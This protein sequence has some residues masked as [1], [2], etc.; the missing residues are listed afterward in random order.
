MTFIRYKKFGNRVYAYEVTAYYDKEQ[1]RPRQKVKYLGKLT[2]EGIK[3]VRSS[4]LPRIS[5]N[6]GDVACL[7][8]IA[9]DIG[10]E[11]TLK[12]CYGDDVANAILALA[13]NR[14]VRGTSLRNFKVWYE[15]TYL[16]KLTPLQNPSSQNLSRIL[17]S[18]GLDERSM[19]RFFKAWHERNGVQSTITY[20]ITSLSSSSS[21]IDILEYGYNRDND[22]LPQLNLGLVAAMETEI[23]L[24]FKVFPGS[25]NDVVTLRNLLLE[26]QSIGMHGTIFILDR[27]FYSRTNIGELSREGMWFVIPMPFHVKEAQQIISRTRVDSPGNAV[28]FKGRRIYMSNGRIEI[29]GEEIGYFLYFDEMRRS[30]ETNTFYSRLIEVETKLNGRKI[31]SW[32][33]AD[34]VVEDVAGKLAPYFSWKVVDGTLRLTRRFRTISRA[35][36]MMGKTILLYN[37]DMSWDTALAFYRSRDMIEKMFE[38]IKN[39]LGTLPLRV[40]KENTVKGYLL[41]IF[42]SLAL[43][44]GLLRR[45]RDS[46]LLKEYSV[47]GLLLELAKIKKIELLDGSE[48][49]SEVSRKERAILQKLQLD[50]IVPKT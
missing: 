46:G 36:N 20:D 23:P 33:Q 41:V 37:G 14:I 11:Q 35:V 38:T 43:Y 2:E 45:M 17:D 21:H 3:R 50:D 6:Y 49:T 39:D 47:E 42:T 29:E 5:L 16:S 24:Y 40:H 13:V 31:H 26:I 12:S 25:I 27:G 10:L 34:R 7:I 8:R 22:E 48:V 44:F 32:E 9:R 18:I 1:K 30:K 28:S 15:D 19:M 4:S